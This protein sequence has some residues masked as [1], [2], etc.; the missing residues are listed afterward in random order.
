MRVI[1]ALHS[2]DVGP[3]GPVYHGINRGG[4]SLRF[5][6]PGTSTNVPPEIST[7]DLRNIN[8]SDMNKTSQN[9]MC[10][11]SFFMSGGRPCEANCVGVTKHV[12]LVVSLCKNYFII[13]KGGPEFSSSKV[14]CWPNLTYQY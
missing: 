4:K 10:F 6:N 2:E 13:Y 11:T 7:F 1:W 5:L 14:L 9:G 8:V 3:S 12:V